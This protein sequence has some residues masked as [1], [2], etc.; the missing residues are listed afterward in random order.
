MRR[1]TQSLGLARNTYGGTETRKEPYFLNRIGRNGS[2]YTIGFRNKK[3]LRLCPV[4]MHVENCCMSYSNFLNFWVIVYINARAWKGVRKRNRKLM[5]L[6]VRC[7]TSNC[8]SLNRHTSLEY[9]FNTK[10]EQ[11]IVLWRYLM[12]INVK[13]KLSEIFSICERLQ[14]HLIKTH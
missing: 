14:V 6:H 13:R 11:R 1:S 7:D 3:L 9:I 2:P 4:V 12:Y 10:R 8:P 5:E